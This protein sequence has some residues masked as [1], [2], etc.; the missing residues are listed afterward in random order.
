VSP[1]HFPWGFPSC[2]RQS[3]DPRAATQEELRHRATHTASSGQHLPDRL[4][5][6]KAPTCAT[7]PTSIHSPPALSDFSQSWDRNTSPGAR[8]DLVATRWS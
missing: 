1:F 7:G 8:S 4:K 2:P 6:R 3:V 5:K